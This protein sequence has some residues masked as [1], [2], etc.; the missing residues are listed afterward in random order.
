MSRSDDETE[1]RRIDLGSPALLELRGPD[2]LR[3]LN[4]QITQDAGRVSQD[5]ISLR[6]TDAGGFVEGFL[7]FARGIGIGDDAGSDLIDQAA[8][9]RGSGC[10]WRC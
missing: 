3:F 7:V 6:Q 4:G 1:A 8:R 5:G 9:P 10:G 2:A